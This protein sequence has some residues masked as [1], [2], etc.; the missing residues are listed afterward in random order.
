MIDE[1]HRSVYQ[2]YKAIFDYFDSLLVGLTATPKDEVDRDTYRLFD[3]QT[4][5]PTDA[6]G[7][8][9]AVEGRL[10]GAAQGG[11]ADHSSSSTAGIRYD[12]LSDEEKEAVG[13][14][15]MGRG[16]RQSRTLS[17]P[18][19]LNKWLFNAD[20]VDQVLEHLM[21]H[22][23][24]GRRTATGWARPSSSPRTTTHAEFIAE[25]FDANY[26]HLAGHFARVITYQ[27]HLRADADR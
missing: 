25:R 19:A 14:T 23:H 3:L 17:M 22:G 20:T 15:G 16:R 26:P 27:D 21:E 12:D 4:G 6:Y 1:A 11:L 5:V 13:R 24:Q 9:E 10:P 18:P 2:K 7:L 8:D